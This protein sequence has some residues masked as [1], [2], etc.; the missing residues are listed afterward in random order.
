M[1]IHTYPCGP[2][3]ANTYIVYAQDSQTCAVIDPADAK[4]VLREL[5]K[6][7]KTCTHILLTHGHFD[8]IYGVKELKDSL[9]CKICIHQNDAT[10]LHSGRS[11][12]AV[13]IREAL[14]PTQADILLNEGDIIEAGGLKFRVIHTPGHS[15]GGVVYA[16]DDQRV[17]FSGDT[18]FYESVGRSDM[19]GCSTQALIDSFF[20]K[21]LPLVGYR[22]LPGHEQQTTV[23]HEAQHNPLIRYSG[24]VH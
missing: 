18:V 9:N 10:A 5:D 6:L 22:L 24:R 3:Y 8:H 12:L 11:S 1:Q 15:P 19:P 4:L 7:G 20:N 21:V 16:I 2:L 14:P 17:A 13:L 23:A